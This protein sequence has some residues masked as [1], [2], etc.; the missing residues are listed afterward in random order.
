MIKVGPS[1]SIAHYFL[2]NKLTLLIV[3]SSL[4]LGLFAALMTPREEEPQIVVPMVDVMIPFPGA[5]PQEVEQRAVAP[6]EKLFWEI[7]GVEYVYSTSSSNFGMVIVRFKVN[8][9]ETD[10][11]VRIYDKMKSNGGLLP[12]GSMEPIVKLHS[13]ADVPVL[14]LTLWGEKA[15]SYDLTRIARE[16]EFKLR[17]VPNVA[18]VEV[19]GAQNREI[20]VNLDPVKLASYSLSPLAIAQSLAAFNSRMPAGSLVSGNEEIKVEAGS[21]LKDKN[22]VG[23]VLV[24]FFSGKP[25]YLGDVAKIDDGEPVP[26]SYVF[27]GLGPAAKEK[28]ISGGP[29]NYPAVTISVAKRTGVNA[30]ELNENLLKKIEELKG[31]LIPGSVNITITR[32]YGETAK[33]K[34]N[35]LI[36]HLLLATFSVVILI[37]LMLGWRESIV[38]GIAVPVTLAF[39]LL[40]YYLSGYT[41]N[42]VTLFALIFSIGILVDD[43]I[44]VVENIYRHFTMKDQRTLVRK[45]IEAVDEVGNPTILAT[46][47]VIAAILPMAFVRGMMGPYMRPIPVGASAAMLISLLVAFIVSPWAAY[48]LL[49]NR[50]AEHEEKEMAL[51]K[52]YRAFMTRLLGSKKLATYFLLGNVLLL[53]IAVGLV[54]TKVV[55]V[56]MLPFDNKSEFQVVLDMPEGTPLEESL[57][58]AMALS[59][60]L[61]EMKEVTDYQ[62]YAGASAPI[63]FNGLVRHYFLRQQPNKADIQVSL[64]PKG[65]RSKQSHELAK[66]ARNLLEPVAKAYGVK[67]KVV[68][69]PP[70]PPVISTLVAE[71]YGPKMDRMLDLG[72][73]VAELFRKTDS[74]VDTDIFMLEPQKNLVIDVDPKR[75]ASMGISPMEISNSLAMLMGGHPPQY[76]H[77]EDERESVPIK[78]KFTEWAMA[79]KEAVSSIVLPNRTGQM[80]PLSQ[81]ADIRMEEVPQDIYHKNLQ[82]VVYVVAE[83]AGREESPV[84]AMMKLNRELE[85]LDLGGGKVGLD[86]LYTSLPFL[87]N[88]EV[89]KWDGEWQI[90]YEVFRDLGIAFALV[91]ILMY[92]MIVG[93]FKSYLTPIAIMA[94][95]P[96]SLVGI[97]PAHGLFGA[98]FTATS[99]IGFIALA[100]VVVR[101]SILVID[102]AEMKMRQGMGVREAL[103]EGGAVRFRP[104]LLTALA[105]VVGSSVM[106]MDP[107]FQGM[108]LALISGE[109]ASTLLSWGAIPI[110]Y[111]FFYGDKAPVSD[112][113]FTEEE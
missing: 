7:P 22:D 52:Y 112:E 108:A 67:M 87:A 58:A 96:L 5:T 15:S 40:I 13:I 53:L 99:M 38:V 68:E 64:L 65:D 111:W 35:E 83:V 88:S 70:G 92:I 97:I 55:K 103:I 34:S 31:R 27:M 43:A 54:V 16:V 29:G 14:S 44:V 89:M 79:S 71:I 94:P 66:E 84:Y 39:T 26:K 41:L 76:A 2:K 61:K 48:K 82:R 10:A 25:V 19:L 3:I 113:A 9:D 95:I 93:W 78:L 105:V 75:A 104:M 98:F 32:N 109:V 23:S 51:L 12:Q 49:K 50:K 6:L 85:K 106:L 80:I 59:E 69:I 63:T 56:K 37:A 77:V 1:G 91:L 28:G 36:E 110:L 4:L 62:I 33:D 72:K 47:T 45:A 90:T 74:V 101:N 30:T 100:G 46:F 21:W 86:R 17:E 73:K 8:S 57:R 18:S 42:R 60:K 20:R 81:V 24:G 107:I 11:M 102:F